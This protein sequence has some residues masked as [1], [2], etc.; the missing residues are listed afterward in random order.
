MQNEQVPVATRAGL[1]ANILGHPLLTQHHQEIVP[2]AITWMQNEQVLVP[3][4][5]RISANILGSVGL[6]GGPSHL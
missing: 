4:R 2:L 6:W 5:A 3:I 1:A